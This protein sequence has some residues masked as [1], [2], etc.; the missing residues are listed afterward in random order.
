M[1]NRN[2]IPTNPLRAAAAQEG[3]SRAQ[4]IQSVARALDIVET[5]AATGRAMP[6]SAL[7]DRTG[8]KPSTCHHLLGTLV[9]RGWVRHDLRTR[10]YALGPRI[11]ELASRPANASS[12]LPVAQTAVR[13]LSAGT[14]EAVHLATMQGFELVTLLK[15]DSTHA[16]RVDT[17]AVGKSQAAHATATGKALIAWWQRAQLDDLIQR[18]S[19]RRFTEHTIVEPAR[20]HDHLA[21]VRRQGWAQDVEEFQPGV[22]C[23]G[24]P[25][26]GPGGNVVAAVSC[27]MPT[28]RSNRRTAARVRALVQTCTNDISHRLGHRPSTVSTVSP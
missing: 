5:L 13:E 3:R 10:E 7:V 21:R 4:H 9:A 28:M 16:V 27:S 1:S 24:A 26:R 6:L 15:F 23:I 25:V 14:G 12:V 19:L 8:L 11:N 2:E 22:H 20:L 18:V 17:G